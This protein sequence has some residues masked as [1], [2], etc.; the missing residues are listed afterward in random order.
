MTL[1]VDGQPHHLS[2]GTT[3]FVPANRPHGFRVVGTEPLRTLA[4]FA[5]AG[6]AVFFREVGAPTD[7]RT[8]PEYH[9]PTNEDLER[10]AATSPKH[11]M[12][13]LGP[14]PPAE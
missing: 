5:P 13:R 2:P 1:Y 4:I 8:L 6:M 7:S 9:G 10:M 11:D 14:L 3:G 12:Q